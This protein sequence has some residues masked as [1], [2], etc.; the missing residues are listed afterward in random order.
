LDRNYSIISIPAELSTGA[1][2]WIRTKNSD[3]RNTSACFLEFTLR[4][5]S[6]VH[7]AY[8]SRA[9]SLPLWLEDFEPTSLSIGV[10]DLAMGNFVVFKK[11]ISAGTLCLGGNLATGA[12]NVGSN[13]TVIVQPISP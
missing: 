6:I 3:K 7:I 5:D 2:E 13:Y 8:D 11:N 4:Q 9:T 12:A 10:S 1:E